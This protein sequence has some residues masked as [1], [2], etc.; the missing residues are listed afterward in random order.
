LRTYRL[1]RFAAIVTI[2][3]LMG[4]MLL[5]GCSRPQ[6]SPS[7]SQPAHGTHEHD[8]GHTENHPSQLILST[9][10]GAAVRG[11]SVQLTGVIQDESGKPIKDFEPTHEKLVHLIIVREGLDEF[12][13]VHPSIDAEGKLSVEHTFPK[14]GLYHLFTDYKSKGSSP[15]TARTTINVSGDVSAAPS[16]T[17]DVPGRIQGDG[18]QADVSVETRDSAQIVSFKVLDPEGN[19]VTDLQPYLGAMGHLV[20]ISASAADY[21]H[22]HPLD[23]KSDVGVVEFDVHF[24]GPGIYKA[25]GQFQRAG[26]VFTFPAVINF[27]GG[28]HQ[29]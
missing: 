8:S 27:K 17:P 22:A 7:L 3:F 18:L 28:G 1:H 12:V 29:H 5:S 19:A 15:S 24:P 25:W 20:V 6:P 9:N 13:H 11:N 21:V 10:P 23:S 4:A 16:L 14:A 26:K 2:I